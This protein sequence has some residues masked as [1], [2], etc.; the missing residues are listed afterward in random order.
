V[1]DLYQSRRAAAEIREGTSYWNNTEVVKTMLALRHL[2]LLLPA[3]KTMAVI[4]F[5]KAQVLHLKDK[6]SEDPSLQALVESQ[7]L[8]ILS[9]DAC[10]GSEADVIILNCVRSLPESCGPGRPIPFFANKNR[11]CV[12]TSRAKHLLLLI[13]CGATLGQQGRFFE[14]VK[15][16]TSKGTG[17]PASTAAAWWQILSEKLSMRRLASDELSMRRLA[18]DEYDRIQRVRSPSILLSALCGAQH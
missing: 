16:I 9:V 7:R 18:S 2:H 17:I 11:F 13:G 3:S 4:S 12:A 10:Q 8:R 6:V 14:H 5:Y 15:L 1:L